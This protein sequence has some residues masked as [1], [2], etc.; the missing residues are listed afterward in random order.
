MPIPT[1]DALSAKLRF[2]DCAAEASL[3]RF[4]EFNQ[5]KDL[6][7]IEPA[8]LRE[9]FFEPTTSSEE[10]SVGLFQFPQGIR[11]ETGSLQTDEIQPAGAGRYTVDQEIRQY[12]LL[13]FGIATGHRITADATELM[14]YDTTREK[15]SLFDFDVARQGDII[16]EDDMVIKDALMRHVGVSHEK[17]M[18]SDTRGSPVLRCLVHRDTLPKD[19]AVPDLEI[20]F[21]VVVFQVLRRTAENC[22]FKNLIPVTHPR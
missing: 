18:A 4:H 8:Q 20:G 7:S 15:G 12:I 16:C 3:R 22:P 6:R 11:R 2:L 5:V 13:H 19:I 1:Q 14:H 9:P 21:G 17:T 10:K